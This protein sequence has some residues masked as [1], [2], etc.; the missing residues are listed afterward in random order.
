MIQCGHCGQENAE[1]C[2]YC[3]QC[4]RW[5]PGEVHERKAADA[6]AT[7]LFR[8]GTFPQLMGAE[9][10]VEITSKKQLRAEADKRNMYSRYLDG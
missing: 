4:F 2:G 3:A 5:L 9:S 7:H 10:K 8:A 1:G 6:P